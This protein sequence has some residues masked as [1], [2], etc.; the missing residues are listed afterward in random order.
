MTERYEPAGLDAQRPRAELR[1]RRRVVAGA[2][3]FG[4]GMLGLS[5]S[6]RPGSRLFYATT[7]GAAATWTAGGLAASSLHRPETPRALRSLGTTVVAPV[8]TGASAFGVFYGGALVA[9]RIPRIDAALRTVLR[10]ADQG[11][12]PLVLVTTLANGLAEEVFFRGA[13][14]AAAGDRYPVMVST[15]VYTLVTA[16][17]RNYALVLA[18]AAMGTVFGLQRRATG[19]ITAP[20]LTHATWAALMV[21]YLPPLFEPEHP[22]NKA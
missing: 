22:N 2:S 8:L 3:A 20:V 4:A 6:T 1:R 9:R 15:A 12:Q 16:A 18:A 14:Y 21:R 11:S 17:T 13:V 19:G 5:F 7:L 10:F